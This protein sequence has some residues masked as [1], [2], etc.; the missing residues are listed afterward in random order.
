MR[1]L[2]IALAFVLAL[3]AV[4]AAQS[5]GGLG[6]TSPFTLSISPQYPAP[7]SKAIVTTNSSTVDLGNATM[8]LFVAGKSVYKGDVQPVSI[9]LGAAGSVTTVKVTVTSGGTTTNYGQIGLSHAIKFEITGPAVKPK[10][11]GW[12]MKYQ[13]IHD[14]AKDQA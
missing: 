8:N 11:M 7:N 13:I 14:D 12:G 5:L 10:L 6:D 1:S 2:L 3:P 9:T 4:A